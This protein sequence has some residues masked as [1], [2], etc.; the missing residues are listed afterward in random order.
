[1]VLSPTLAVVMSSISLR[2]PANMAFR[3]A[4]STWPAS[5][6]RLTPSPPIIVPYSGPAEPPLTS[7]TAIPRLSRKSLMESSPHWGTRSWMS[8]AIFP[9]VMPWSPSPKRESI[10]LRYWVF[11]SSSLAAWSSMAP[12]ASRS[13]IMRPSSL[14]DPVLFSPCSCYVCN[15]II[16][17]QVTKVN[18]FCAILPI[19]VNYTWVFVHI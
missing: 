15:K 4:S 17:M 16:T 9:M 8:L 1:M 13:K 7:I 19:M 10:S 5:S 12:R 3:P 2:Q 6:S 18:Q 11:S 14:S